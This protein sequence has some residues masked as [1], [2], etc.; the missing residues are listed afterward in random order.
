M[1][2]PFACNKAIICCNC[3]VLLVLMYKVLFLLTGNACSNANIKTDRK[4]RCEPRHLS[5]EWQKS[6]W[7]VRVLSSVTGCVLVTACLSVTG[8]L[9][10]NGCLLMTGPWL[11]TGCLQWRI[12]H[13]WLVVS[14]TSCLSVTSLTMLIKYF[15]FI[16]DWSLISDGLFASDWSLISDELSIIDWLFRRRV[17]Y[18][19]LL[20]QAN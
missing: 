6:G 13:H 16:S 1:Q 17:F 9:S 18:Q 10:L 4:Y 11:L 3:W 19:W 12:V 5:R 7:T 14:V 15:Y 2:V 8:R 20:W